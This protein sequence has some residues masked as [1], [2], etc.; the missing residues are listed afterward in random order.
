MRAFFL[1]LLL[2][3]GAPATTAWSNGGGKVFLTVDEAL[4]LVFPGCEIER[5]TVYLT[6]AQKKRAKKLARV[7][8]D[9]GIVRPYVAR[10]GKKVVGT[11]YFDT[12]KVRT[13]RETVMIA[14]DA[15]GRIRR[16]ELL[17]F[18]EPEDYIPR[19]KWYG[20]FK[21]KRLGAGLSLKRDIKGVTGA[22]LTARATTSAARRSLA[23]HE[24]LF[25]KPTT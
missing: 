10:K 18:A 2:C 16:V 3:L 17:A 12:H 4:E 1:I 20:Q 11:A 24:V 21:G 15:K 9:R 19:G 23:L 22:T 14:V 6:D 8:L 5:Q 7:K 13:K 25:G